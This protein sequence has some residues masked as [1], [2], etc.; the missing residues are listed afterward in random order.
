M[1]ELKTESA[2]LRVKEEEHGTL[3]NILEKKLA[4]FDEFESSL[5]NQFTKEI[6]DQTKVFARSTARGLRLHST[7]SRARFEGPELEGVLLQTSSAKT[8]D[9]GLVLNL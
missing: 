7:I 9:G 4:A 2:K 3:R 1:C 5:R 8:D 6:N